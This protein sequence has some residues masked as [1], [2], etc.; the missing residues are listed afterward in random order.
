VVAVWS[1]RKAALAGI[2]AGLLVAC[3]LVSGASDLRG[4]GDDADLPLPARRPAVAFGA[5]LDDGGDPGSDGGVPPLTC[6][7]GSNGDGRTCSARSCK[8]L[9]AAHPETKSGVYRLDPGVVGHASFDAYC[10]MTSDGG[11]WTLVHKNNLANTNDRTDDGYNVAALTT[12]VVDDVAVLPRAIMAALS[13]SNEF[14]V[15][16]TNGF[17]VYSLGG[18]AYY[19]TDLHVVTKYKGMMKYDGAAEYT[20]QAEVSVS[21]G[22]KHGPFVCPPQGCT[23][24]DPGHLVIQRWCCGEPN[25]GFWFNGQRF[26]PG[27]HAG[28]GWVR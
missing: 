18:S 23:G 10:D 19:T 16:A 26:G 27:Y 12:P 14:R 13:P 5:S 11:G 22:M 25:A 9:L 7:G 17:A 21:T 28:T 3:T 24:N 6:D 4:K 15:L 20:P 1:L 8:E 2:G